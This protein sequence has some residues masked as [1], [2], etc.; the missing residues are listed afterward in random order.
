MSESSF[1]SSLIRSD[2]IGTEPPLD[3]SF[4]ASSSPIE[5]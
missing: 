2:M 1:S 4:E 3:S 5:K